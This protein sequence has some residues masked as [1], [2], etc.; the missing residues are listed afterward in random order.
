MFGI[1]TYCDVVALLLTDDYSARQILYILMAKCSKHV[2][3]NNPSRVNFTSHIWFPY[4]EFFTRFG[5]KWLYWVIFR[6]KID[7]KMYCFCYNK[8]S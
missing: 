2:I 3:E 1:V 7:A 6:N 5:V 8:E 4:L